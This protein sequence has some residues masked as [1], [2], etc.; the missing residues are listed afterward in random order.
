MGYIGNSPALNESVTSAQIAD[1]AI[2]T[3]KINAGAV[4]SDELAAGAVDAAHFASGVGGVLQ[5][6]STHSITA[7]SQV[8]SSL[9]TT[10][11]TNGTS[12]SITPS[13]ASNKVLVICRWNG[14]GSFDTHN[15]VFGIMRDISGGASDTEV[16]MPAG[17][18]SKNYGHQIISQGYAGV[19]TA[20][21]PD[22]ANWQ[23]LDSPGVTTQVTYY[24]TCRHNGGCTVYHNMSVDDTDS[25]GYERLSSGMILMEIAG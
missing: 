13:S 20:S 10:K 17:Y 16:G 14:E 25:S 22:S 11:L 23:Y 15:Q 18:G 8:L 6:V 21:T 1:N 2:T 12:T 24:Q 7:S 5:V 19:D 4:D 3:A 9:T